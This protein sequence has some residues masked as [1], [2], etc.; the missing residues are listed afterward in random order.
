MTAFVVKDW[1]DR[2]HWAISTAIVV[3]AH[4]IIASAIATWWIT[5]KQP[6][7]LGTAP[8]VVELSP[9]PLAQGPQQAAIPVA[10]EQGVPNTAPYK[11]VEKIEETIQERSAKK[12]EDKTETKPAGQSSVSM[13]PPQSADE[14]N[15]ADARSAPGGGAIGALQPG[16]DAESIDIRMGDP[17]LSRLKKKPLNPNERQKIMMGRRMLG[18]SRYFAG[19]EEPLVPVPVT[20]EPTKPGATSGAI[21]NAIGVLVPGPAGAHE[22]PAARGAPQLNAGADL[23]RSAV[24]APIVASTNPTGVPAGAAR[25][26][27][28][29][30]VTRTVSGANPIGVAAANHPSASS[31]V[32]SASARGA[33]VV[34]AIPQIAINGT[35][36][37]RPGVSTGVIGGPA[38]SV[39]GALN[40]TTIKAR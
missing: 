38:N 24:G 35:H 1:P 25:N 21:R 2:K 16:H 32:K 6:E 26:A 29:V 23:A 19:R 22:T 36:M 27:V 11:P 28:G 5:S 39:A 14:E 30:A 37:I 31:V 15:R 33:S 18:P 7:L 10:P 9:A 40:G 3:L 13:A 12:S 34:T 8:I 4:G 20:A 17:Y